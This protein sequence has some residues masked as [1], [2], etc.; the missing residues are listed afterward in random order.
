MFVRLCLGG[1]D[2]DNAMSG[3]MKKPRCG[4]HE[5]WDRYQ[6]DL[7]NNGTFFTFTYNW[8][9]RKSLS[10]KES[11]VYNKQAF[12]LLFLSVLGWIGNGFRCGGRG[13]SPSVS[14][15]LSEIG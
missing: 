7:T 2:F 8:T 10:A 11:R 13:F 4:G 15:L 9:R 14:S 12:S 3:S 5:T 1:H 6:T